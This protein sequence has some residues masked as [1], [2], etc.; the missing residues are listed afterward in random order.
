MFGKSFSRV[1]IKYVFQWFQRHSISRFKMFHFLHVFLKSFWERYTKRIFFFLIFYKFHHVTKKQCGEESW[2]S[3]FFLL[4][5]NRCRPSSRKQLRHKA[6]HSKNSPLKKKD[7]NKW[8]KQDYVCRWNLID[9]LCQKM[10][11]RK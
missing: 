3:Y 2:F 11:F 9:I 7:G 10:S 1:K 8:V 4:N 6:Y 5:L